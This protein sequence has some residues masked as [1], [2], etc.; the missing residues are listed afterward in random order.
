MEVE[1]QET[2]Q[3]LGGYPATTSYTRVKFTSF[4]L[5]IPSVMIECNCRERI[6]KHLVQ[7]EAP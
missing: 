6:L 5:E 7:Q 1:R 3:R 4:I 2:T